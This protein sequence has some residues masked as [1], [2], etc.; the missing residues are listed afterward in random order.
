[1]RI[2]M[3]CVGAIVNTNFHISNVFCSAC[4]ID[5]ET[6][7]LTPSSICEQD[8]IDHCNNL[9]EEPKHD[10]YLKFKVGNDIRYIKYESTTCQLLTEEEFNNAT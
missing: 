1:M 6:G 2:Y 10:I 8:C 3:E 7:N 9:K 4:Y 5:K